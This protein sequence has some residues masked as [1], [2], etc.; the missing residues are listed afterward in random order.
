[1]K[2]YKYKV[3]VVGASL[4]VIFSG[5][6][7]VPLF[8]NVDGIH[9][10]STQQKDSLV[11]GKIVKVAKNHITVASRHR[12]RVVISIDSATKLFKGFGK[13][14]HEVKTTDLQVGDKGYFAGVYDAS[15]KTLTATKVV[16]VRN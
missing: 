7:A 4:A 13:N 6:G 2:I 15:A 10:A 8:N 9:A 3:V 14:K 12:G 5:A 16:H 1:M 11:H